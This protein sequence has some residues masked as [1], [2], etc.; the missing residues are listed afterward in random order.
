MSLH[1]IQRTLKIVFNCELKLLLVLKWPTRKQSS[2]VA[3]VPVLFIKICVMYLRSVDPIS[4][5]HIAVTTDMLTSTF[6]IW[7]RNGAAL[8]LIF[9]VIILQIA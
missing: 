7:A 5:A 3:T 2:V 6:S 9:A 8:S 1:L 4:Y